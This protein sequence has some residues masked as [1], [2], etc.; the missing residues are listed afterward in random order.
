[1]FSSFDLAAERF[2][3]PASGRAWTLPGSRKKPEARKMLLN[4]AD[5]HLSGARFVRQPL[6]LLKRRLKKR[7][8]HQHAKF[9]HTTE[10]LA[11]SKAIAYRYLSLLHDYGIKYGSFSTAAKH[12]SSDKSE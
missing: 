6:R 7:H 10:S 12:S 9:L 3:L 11:T 8:H 1:M 4:R 5:S 2:A